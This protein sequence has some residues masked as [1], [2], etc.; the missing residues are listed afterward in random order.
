[1]HGVPAPTL[2]VVTL[3]ARDCVPSGP[4]VR[5]HDDHALHASTQLRHVDDE[6]GVVVSTTLTSHVDV[7]YAPATLIACVFFVKQPLLV[8]HDATTGPSRHCRSQQTTPSPPM[9][10]PSLYSAAPQVPL[11]R[12]IL[13]KQLVGLGS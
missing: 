3:R 4:H 12:Q 11:V 8:P 13:F 5:E 9:Q 10:V 2:F 7:R 6:H 1:M